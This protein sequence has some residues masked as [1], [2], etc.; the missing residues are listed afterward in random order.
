MEK[1][2]PQGELAFCCRPAAAEDFPFLFSVLKENMQELYQEAFGSWEDAEEQA[3][4][5]QDLAEAPFH[6]LCR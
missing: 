1:E 2:A 6:L 5:R 3:F 4:L